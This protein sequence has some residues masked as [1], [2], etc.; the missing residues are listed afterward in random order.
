MVLAQLSPTPA[1]SRVLV[2]RETH[3][4][5]GVFQLDEKT[6]LVQTVDFFTP[7]VDDPWQYGA[8][9]ATNALSDVWAMGGTP[10]TALNLLAIPAD[11]MTAETAAEILNGGAMVMRQF[12][13]SLI[14][15]HS[16]D[17]PEPKVGYAV[18]GLVDPQKIWR[19][20][21]AVPGDLLYCTKP[22]GTGV[23][24]KAIKDGS[25]QPEWIEAATEMMLEANFAAK[26]ALA[27]IGGPSSCTD[28]TGF[29]LL[30]H[31]WEMAQG[32]EV[33]IHLIAD[34]VPILKGAE[35]LALAGAFPRGSIRNRDYV[36]D[37]LK[38][39]GVSD[40]LLA[41][42][43][44]AVTSGGLLFTINPDQESRLHSAFSGNHLPLWR[45]G[46]VHS[47]PSAIEM[48]SLG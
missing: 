44:D 15:G 45:I 37:H 10:V 34:R 27:S 2:G 16:I 31:T 20:S 26:N 17:D 43:C 24:I 4:D 48:T 5:A 11:Q 35:S 9:S 12:G 46:E 29:G 7:V 30:G 3:D 42:L 33:T 38:A 8:I 36:A 41:L 25:A 32:S 47:G 40:H 22:I 13:V 23:L 39:P 19:N 21:T 18:T 1:D 6:A 14:G 28:I